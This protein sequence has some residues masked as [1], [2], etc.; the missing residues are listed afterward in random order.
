M[1]LNLVDAAI[2]TVAVVASV[3]AATIAGLDH[4]KLPQHAREPMAYTVEIV[5]GTI[6]FAEPGE[7][8]AAGR[9]VSPEPVDTVLAQ[10]LRVMRHQVSQAD[11]QLCVDAGA[12]QP[13]DAVANAA[14]E[15][16]PVTG[17]SYFDATAYANWLSSATEQ[18]WRLPTAGEWAY[19][20]AERF[21]GETYSPAAEDKA[22]PAVA[23]IRRYRE[24]AAAARKP[25]PQPKPNGFYGPNSRGVEDLAGNVW[26]WTATCYQRVALDGDRRLISRIENCGVHV[27]EGRHRAYMSNFIRDG[28]SGGC[29]V[30][31]PPE[32]LGFRLVLERGNDAPAV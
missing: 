21:V 18:S 17:I 31:T 8:L 4:T 1:P 29:A 28:R 5:S 14:P 22:N 10:P 25:D 23:W 26:E 30:G 20:A 2:A 27:V 16:I 7:F 11:Y 24:E 12:C 15:R 3:A 13:A 9:P 32:N 6:G 19:I